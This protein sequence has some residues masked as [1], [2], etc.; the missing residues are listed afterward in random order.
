MNL[1]QLR[2]RPLFITSAILLTFIITVLFIHKSLTSNSV[3][4][5]VAIGTRHFA[6]NRSHIQNTDSLLTARE[7][8]INQ[9]DESTA[10]VF[11][12][13]NNH[14]LVGHGITPSG[15]EFL[16]PSTT[17]K[18]LD[19]TGAESLITDKPVEYSTLSPDGTK[20]IYITNDKHTY[21]YDIAT[22]SEQLITSN[23]AFLPDLCSDNNRIVYKKLPPSYSP[24]SDYTN[25]P[26]LAITTLSTSTEQL[27][28]TYNTSLTPEHPDYSFIG[29]ADYAPTFS[30]DCN[31]VV[32]FSGSTTGN[33]GGMFMINS[34]GTSRTRLT[35]HNQ[36]IKT[37]D[38]IPSISDSPLFTPDG[39]SFVYESN[40]QIIRANIDKTSRKIKSIEKL[41][42]GI[43]PEIDSL[44][45][46]QVKVRQKG[47]RV[48]KI[49][50][51]N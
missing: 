27:L 35:N 11:K 15:G 13:R 34:D 12:S 18:L 6:I 8:F 31:T 46:L 32:F 50:I 23:A 4:D 22:K 38:T 43:A 28:T 40:Y 1:T 26:G 20:I 51:S 36:K 24:G 17:L 45:P 3:T 21:L 33:I 14:T 16:Q 10:F 2:V 19:N 42:S 41:G 9:S 49:N 44:N 39:S 48:E 47:E 30:P 29:N 5:K 25:S 7:V 37:A